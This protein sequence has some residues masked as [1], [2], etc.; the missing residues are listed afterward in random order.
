MAAYTFKEEVVRKTL[1]QNQ[2]FL[3][4]IDSLIRTRSSNPG[5][6]ERLKWARKDVE[7]RMTAAEI[8]EYE[9]TRGGVALTKAEQDAKW[10]A[11]MA[12]MEQ[13]R[14]SNSI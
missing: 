12:E 10:A 11:D 5:E 1:N 13:N 4:N 2:E 3:R 7:S 9:A 14:D 6:V 8:A